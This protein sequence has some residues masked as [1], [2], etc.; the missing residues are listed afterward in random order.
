MSHILSISASLLCHVGLTFPFYMKTPGE[1]LWLHMGPTQADKAWLP[2]LS[3][4]KLI[5]WLRTSNP[6]VLDSQVPPPCICPHCHRARWNSH[7]AH[8][9]RFPLWRRPTWRWPPCTLPHWIHFA[10]ASH[11]YILV[12]DPHGWLVRKQSTC[13]SLVIHNQVEGLECI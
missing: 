10:L 13:L 5:D 1:V 7:C 11:W 3:G 8:W 12:D 4:A 9:T 6:S 2:H